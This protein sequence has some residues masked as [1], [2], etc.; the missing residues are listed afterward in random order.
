MNIQVIDILKSDLVRRFH[1]TIKSIKPLQKKSKSS[2]L[3][4]N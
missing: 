4:K 3:R 2:Y 1:R